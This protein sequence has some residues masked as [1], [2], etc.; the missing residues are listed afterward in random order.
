MRISKS[1]LL[2]SFL[3][4]F[5]F[6]ITLNAQENIINNKDLISEIVGNYELN[7]NGRILNFN[8]LFNSQE[9]KFYFEAISNNEKLPAKEMVPVE[10]TELK[11]T[12]H[13]PGNQPVEISFE[14]DNKG[15]LTKCIVNVINKGLTGQ[16]KKIS[17]QINNIAIKPPL[18]VNISGKF[19]VEQMSQLVKHFVAD[20]LVAGGEILII[21]NKQIVLHEVYGWS[22]VERKLPLQKNSIYRIRSMTKPF[23]GTAILILYEEGKLL[24]D[25]PVSV[26]LSSFKNE[27]S[28]NITIRQL[29]THR[30]GFK[31]VEMPD[32]YWEKNN[33]R[34]A[35]NFIGESG[36][37]GIPGE[38]FEY[39]DKNS[40]VLGAIICE[41]TG[42]PV[43]DFLKKRIFT[44]LGLK[45]TFTNYSPDFPWAKRVNSTYKLSNNLITK[46]WDNTMAQEESFFRA[47]GG[48]YSSIT[49]YANFLQMWMD[50]GQ[51]SGIRMLKSTTVENALIKYDQLGRKNIGYGMHWEIFGEK[52]NQN[53]LPPFG[54][55]GSDGTYAIAI[56]EKNIMI[57]FFTQTRG[58]IAI[59][60]EL[61]PLINRLYF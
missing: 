45:S 21:K 40:A 17:D 46:Y 39:S 56:P 52:V 4:S 41:L 36:P 3:M 43:E 49:D 1:R 42:Y 35:V 34:D 12:S 16:A 7:M 10:G 50:L 55:E 30:S 48:I 27:K 44:P 2:L 33:L 58:N 54:H 32:G 38:K 18:P 57:L 60:S 13:D 24:L 20:S 61:V 11:F 22:D 26:Y 14:K 25:D 6:F 47:S 28:G 37:E 9:K 51:Y 59:G 8:I 23:I 29:L 19:D 53:T 15:K 5:T 31:Q